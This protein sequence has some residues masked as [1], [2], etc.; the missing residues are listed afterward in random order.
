MYRSFFHARKINL[1]E[2]NVVADCFPWRRSRQVLH[3]DRSNRL[4][5][6][7]SRFALVFTMPN[8]DVFVFC[9][10]LLKYEKDA[11]HVNP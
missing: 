7:L 8:L 2:V 10:E 9:P 11:A 5:T 4:R 3:S 1:L 6:F